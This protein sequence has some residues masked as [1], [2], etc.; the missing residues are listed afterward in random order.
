MWAAKYD[1]SVSRMMA[2]MLRER[3]RQEE[4]YEDAMERF[5]ARPARV[6]SDGGPLP[7]RASIHERDSP[8]H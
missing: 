1:T 6:I 4:D 8:Q 5:L 7:D 3:M 2:E